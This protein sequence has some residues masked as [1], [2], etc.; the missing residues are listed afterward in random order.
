M[1]LTRPQTLPVAFWRA[2]RALDDAYPPPPGP[3][4]PRCTGHRGASLCDG[5]TGDVCLA[6]LMRRK[7]QTRTYLTELRWRRYNRPDGYRGL[8]AFEAACH[9]W[10]CLPGPGHIAELSMRLNPPDCPCTPEY[11]TWFHNCITGGTL[12]ASIIAGATAG[13]H[14]HPTA[15]P[16]TSFDAR[17][18]PV[19]S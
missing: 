19:S 7:Q 18:A 9:W 14:P 5:T 13:P 8:A 3:A 11:R 17:P 1:T 6:K 15:P 16:T 12:P 10:L 2:Y 4:H